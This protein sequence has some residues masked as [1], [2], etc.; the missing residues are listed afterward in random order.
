[1]VR[2]PLQYCSIDATGENDSVEKWHIGGSERVGQHSCVSSAL[3]YT[4][5]HL[6][7]MRSGSEA[8]AKM[9][10]R[11]LLYGSSNNFVD[12]FALFDFTSCHLISCMKESSSV[13]APTSGPPPV[14]LPNERRNAD[15]YTSKAH[16]P[17][18]TLSSAGP[19]FVHFPNSGEPGCS[20]NTVRSN[21]YTTLYMV[22]GRL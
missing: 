20:E 9:T 7:R 22:C 10:K 13:W 21:P 16:D 15:A 14:S 4:K 18:T 3:A 2:N 11:I 1:M 17:R 5:K 12:T 19:Y 8:M 6:M